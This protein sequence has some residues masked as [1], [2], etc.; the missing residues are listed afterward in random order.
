ML[1]KRMLELLE[2]GKYKVKRLARGLECVLQ[3][4]RAA[5]GRGD[6]GLL[7]AVLLPL[8]PRLP[9]D[10]LTKHFYEQFFDAIFVG[11]VHGN[12]SYY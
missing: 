12:T 4:V 2:N 9:R 11:S 6:A 10:L 5:G 7:R 1:L 3:C 8:L